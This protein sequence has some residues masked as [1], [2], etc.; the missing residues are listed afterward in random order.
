MKIV[1]KKLSDLK[2]PE[3]NIRLHTDKQLKEFARSV[4]MFGQ[5]R[6]IVI[7]ENNVMLAGNG[8]HATLVQLGHTEANCYVVRG[9]SEA[10]KKKLM[11]ADNRVFDLGVDDMAAFD[12]FILELKD[13]LDIPGF[14]EDMLKSFVMDTAEADALLSEYGVLS[15][16]RADE[17]RDTRAR[18][19]EREAA[20][21]EGAAEYTP[22]N[23][24]DEVRD[25]VGHTSPYQSNAEQNKFIV[26][27]K[28][29]DRIWL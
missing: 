16:D 11:L 12:A 10:E 29:G 26:C 25:A 15:S 5:I 6:P 9:L 14:D 28:C 4:T 27:P 1:K 2:S 17:I 24:P 22:G 20:A 7:D 23:V 13:D 18:Y 3:R 19:D 21:A 8:L